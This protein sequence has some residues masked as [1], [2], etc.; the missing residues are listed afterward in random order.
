MRSVEASAETL[1]DTTLLRE[2]GQWEKSAKHEPN[3]N[4]EGRASAREIMAGLAVEEARQ[5]LERFLESKRV[6]SLHLGH[7]RTATLREV[8]S[9]TLTEYLAH[10]LL[11]S[12]EQRAHHHAVKLAAREH[13]GQLISEFEKATAYHHATRELVAEARQREPSFTDKEKINLEIY[14]ERQND[15]SA[16]QRYLDL[17]RGQSQSREGNVSV[18][19]GR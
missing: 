10:A 9:R 16:R 13:H 11:D 19:R 2:V 6:T 18:A 12:R 4:W 1:R 15:E 8:Q 7:H 3:S 17:A 14:A 5:R